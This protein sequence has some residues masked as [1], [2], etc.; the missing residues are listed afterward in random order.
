MFVP[1]GFGGGRV[2]GAGVTGAGDAGGFTGALVLGAFAGA[3][4][5]GAFAGVFVLGV[6]GAGTG[7]VTTPAAAAAGLGGLEGLAGAAGT[8]GLP[9]GA[10]LATGFG[11]PEMRTESSPAPASGCGASGLTG[12]GAVDS[13]SSGPTTPVCCAGRAHA[14]RPARASPTTAV[15]SC[16]HLMPCSCA[17]SVPA[18]YEILACACSTVRLSVGAPM[19]AR[20]VVRASQAPR[21][22]P[23]ARSTRQPSALASS[24]SR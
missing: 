12:P 18:R 13:P 22:C 11:G 21:V 20:C 15:R 1:G 5:L 14:V 7:T 17:S 9:V 3:F 6:D 4:V 24:R 23:R 16:M 10:G 8:V 2:T 19:R